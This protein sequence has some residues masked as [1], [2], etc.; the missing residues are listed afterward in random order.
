VIGAVAVAVL[1]LLLCGVTGA[2]GKDRATARWIEFSILQDGTLL[3]CA[4]A[5]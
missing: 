4:V 1:L 3:S 2:G 5:E